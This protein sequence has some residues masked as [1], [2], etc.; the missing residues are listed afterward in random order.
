MF[1]KAVG[2]DLDFQVNQ[3]QGCVLQDDLTRT[4]LLKKNTPSDTK[5]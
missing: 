1:L 3:V 5:H 4:E 2:L